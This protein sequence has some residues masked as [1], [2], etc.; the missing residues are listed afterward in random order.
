METHADCAGNLVI[1]PWRVL[2]KPVPQHT[3]AS[4]GLALKLTEWEYAKTQ[5]AVRTAAKKME[6]RSKKLKALNNKV[7]NVYIQIGRASCR[8]RV[9]VCV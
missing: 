9:F 6:K 2:Y 8:E 7:E 1:A 4:K 3:T 5:M